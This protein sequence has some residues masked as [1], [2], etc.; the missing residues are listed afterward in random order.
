[1]WAEQADCREVGRE[2]ELAVAAEDCH[3][4][5]ADC[6]RLA[7]HRGHHAEER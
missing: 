6:R 3:Q 2:L 1:M 7:Q 4:L 5:G